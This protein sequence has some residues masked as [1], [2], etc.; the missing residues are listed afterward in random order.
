M[1]SIS[2]LLTPCFSQSLIKNQLVAFCSLVISASRF[3]ML[4]ALIASRRRKNQTMIP[5]MQKIKMSN[6][7]LTIESSILIN[8]LV[9]ILGPCNRTTAR[10]LLLLNF[11]WSWLSISVITNAIGPIAILVR[12]GTRGNYGNEDYPGYDLFH[13]NKIQTITDIYK[14]NINN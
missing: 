10:L 9:A 12:L 1:V 4:S 5:R 11:L 14:R 2:S 8:G 7:G 13:P 6:W 3:L